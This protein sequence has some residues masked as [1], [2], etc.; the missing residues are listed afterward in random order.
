VK[1]GFFA[2][3]TDVQFHDLIFGDIF[4][5]TQKTM[6]FLTTK[7]L[8]SRISYEGIQ[9]I[10]TLPVP[11]EALREAVLNALIHRDY[12]VTAPI[13]IRVFAARL[14][15]W[16]PGKSPE[17]WDE[18]T[19]RKNHRSRP[20]NQLIASAVF[21]AGE[22]ESWGRGFD[23]IFQKCKAAGAPKP[24]VSYDF[25]SREMSLSFPYR[26]QIDSV[27]TPSSNP[28]SSSLA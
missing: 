17:G 14:D 8:K 10:E 9:R 19:L 1:I 18:Q 26:T 15:I 7:Y 28:S 13:Q 27:Q 21:L 3:S 20:W 4:T 6:E 24:T 23:L 5:Q 16:N 11:P 25:K 2:S 22:V 12:S